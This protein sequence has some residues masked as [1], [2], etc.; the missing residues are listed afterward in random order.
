MTRLLTVL[1]LLLAAGAAQAFDTYPLSGP[2]QRCY[3]VAMVGYDSVINARMGVPPEQVLELVQTR[4]ED[5]RDLVSE[6]L[7]GDYLLKVIMGAYLWKQ[8]P[9]AYAVDT[10]YRCAH[11][12]AGWRQAAR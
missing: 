4:D 2:A 10:F 3:A 1:S 5:G 8:S 11:Q 7:Y 12:R 6:G 9:H